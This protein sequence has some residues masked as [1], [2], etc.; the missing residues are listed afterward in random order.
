ME[1][2]ALRAAVLFGTFIAM[3][4]IVLL[5]AIW[6]WL[7]RSDASPLKVVREYDGNIRFFARSFA[8]FVERRFSG[9]LAN[10]RRTGHAHDGALPDGQQFHIAPADARPLLQDEELLERRVKRMVLAHGALT[11]DDDL[12]FDQEIYADGPINGGFHNVYRAVLSKND[13]TLADASVVLRWLHAEGMFI[14]ENACVLFGRVSAERTIKL[15]AGTTF[16]RMHAQVIRFGTG[17]DRPARAFGLSPVATQTLPGVVDSRGD[18]ILVKG[19]ISIPPHSRVVGSLV[20]TGKVRIGRGSWITGNIKGNDGISIESGAWIDGA[21]VSSENLRVEERSWIKGP[22]VAER[23]VSIGRNC[24]LGSPDKLTTI[25]ADAIL[26]ACDV[27]AYG[28]VWARTAGRV[29]DR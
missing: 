28:T 1:T 10:A 6:E 22:I 5:P 4:G 7:G 9:M 16:T 3:T 26:I 8:A 20:A 14:C 25:S 27:T 24:R 12:T 19:D 15:G 17:A 23:S 18:R 29:A 21:V 2:E 11:L 13:I